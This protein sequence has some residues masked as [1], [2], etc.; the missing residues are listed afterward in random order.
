MNTTAVLE[1]VR[2]VLTVRRVVGDPIEREGVVVIPVVRVRG[3]LG[4]G[5][6]PD[7]TT[8]T[9][10]R[11]GS[12]G[13]G[14][15]MGAKPLGVYVI[16][17]GKVSWLPAVDVNKLALGGQIVAIAAILAFGFRRRACTKREAIPNES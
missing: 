11:E 3:G 12:F 7:D 2:D 5:A 4:G 8:E 13:G 16:R 9:G 15:L 6:E 14:M 10:T 1:D 17:E